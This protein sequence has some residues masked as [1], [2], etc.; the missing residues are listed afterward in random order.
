MRRLAE[1]ARALP[2]R[3]QHALDRRALCQHADEVAGHVAARPAPEALASEDRPP[4]PAVAPTVKAI[5]PRHDGPG[6]V[7]ERGR[8]AHVESRLSEQATQ[9]LW[10]ARPAGVEGHAPQSTGQARGKGS[11]EC[12]RGAE[13]IVEGYEDQ[14]TGPE[15]AVDL[16]KGLSDLFRPTEVE[17]RGDPDHRVESAVL[18]GAR[19]NVGDGRLEMR[20]SPP[21]P[22]DDNG[23]D[24]DPDDSP[25]TCREVR[26]EPLRRH[27]V[28][29]VGLQDSRQRP[30]Q[31]PAQHAPVDR[32]ALPPPKHGPVLG[33]SQC[34]FIPLP[35]GACLGG[36]RRAESHR[37]SIPHPPSVTATGL[38][39]IATA[40]AGYELLA[41][42]DVV[43]PSGRC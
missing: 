2:D 4:Q 9:T 1:E 41:A 40:S 17:E 14:T 34:S 22:P 18:E 23:R 27:L 21:R 11:S 3:V 7:E 25:G 8:V 28:E 43:A 32:I 5:E 42:V 36:R 16:G 26:V 33:P 29:E 35:P 31:P 20:V 15:H 10:P 38:P 37:A 19:T 13:R 24:I 39:R 12:D 6:S 30:G